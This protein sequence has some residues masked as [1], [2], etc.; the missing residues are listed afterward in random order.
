[1]SREKH[2]DGGYPLL[3]QYGMTSGALNSYMP[4]ANP[5]PQTRV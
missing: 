4:F 1:L 5:D 3:K 2:A